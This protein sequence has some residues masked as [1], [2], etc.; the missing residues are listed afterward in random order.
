MDSNQTLGSGPTKDKDIN[1]VI[2]GKLIEVIVGG[3]DKAHAALC[4]YTDSDTS[5]GRQP[6]YVSN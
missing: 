1:I 4:E 3:E 5:S 6:F 2:N